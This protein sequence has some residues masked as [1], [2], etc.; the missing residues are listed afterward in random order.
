MN[1]EFCELIVTIDTREQDKNRV[2][3]IYSYFEDRGAC[4]LEESLKRCDY[5]IEGEYNN[6]LVNLGIEYKTLNDFSGSYKDLPW[7]LAEAHDLFTHVGLFVETGKYDLADSDTGTLIRNYALKDMD[8]VLRYSTLQNMLR[9]FEREG[10]YTQTFINLF[11]FP[12]SIHNLL[13]YITKESHQGLNFKGKDYDSTFR[14]VLIK[15]PG[16]G[17]K[18]AQKG[19]ENFTSLHEICILSENHLQDVW[20]KKTGSKVYD[21]VFRGKI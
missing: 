10:I 1:D 18:G 7:K 14:N 11:E 3:S 17:I 21:F 12:R 4:V 20:G 6:S 16:I 5:W 8:G 19:V 13:N 2:K 9:T 15:L